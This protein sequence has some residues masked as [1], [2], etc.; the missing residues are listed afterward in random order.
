MAHV[1]DGKAGAE[2]LPGEGGEGPPPPP[3]G[4]GRRGAGR[5]RRTSGASSTLSAP[6][7]SS[8]TSFGGG[9]GGLGGGP[10]AAAEEAPGGGGRARVAL[11]LARA[12]LRAARG[13]AEAGGRDWADG[14]AALALEKVLESLGDPGGDR[15]CLRDLYAAAGV[16]RAWRVAARSAAA[17]PA[18]LSHVGAS[19]FT[20]PSQLL[21]RAATCAMSQVRCHVVRQRLGMGLQRYAM[22][23]GEAPHPGSKL[24]FWGTLRVAGTMSRSHVYL[25]RQGRREALLTL[26][27]SLAG[28]RF[29][30]ST[31]AQALRRAD[32]A[33]LAGGA[34][35]AQ[36]ESI[37]YF[38]N[39]ALTGHAHSGN[40]PRKIH[41]AFRPEGGGAAA[42]AGA[43]AGAAGSA[44]GEGAP[45]TVLK[46][47]PPRWHPHLQCWC[48][49]FRGRIQM[50]SVKNI[51]LVEEGAKGGEILLQFGKVEPDVYSLDFDPTRLSALN[52]FGIALSNFNSHAAIEL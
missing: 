52:A 5:V 9:R 50:A 16:S 21:V 46:N 40:G 26:T 15:E 37:K 31:H 36:L 1:P 38:Y 6:S 35:P 17:G 13:A 51:Q 11:T 14:V 30:V 25:H 27:S 34:P 4:P 39:L 48:L 2:G 49:D 32:T 22:W 44:P 45:R 23:S 3:R 8:V 10:G 43:G 47:K 33:Q 12:L 29:S 28:N 24:L 7:F 41:V 42:G 19:G 18:G 20:H